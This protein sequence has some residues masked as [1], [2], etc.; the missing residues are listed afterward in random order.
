MFI[1]IIHCISLQICDWRLKIMNINA[2]YCGSTHD[3]YIWNNSNVK[4]AMIHLYRRYSNNNF[5]LVGK[6]TYNLVHSI[7]IKY[8][9]I[10]FSK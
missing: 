7:N 3:A 9:K 2:R 5:Y 1:T 6:I 8:K 10:R 4:N